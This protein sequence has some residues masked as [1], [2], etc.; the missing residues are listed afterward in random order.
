M[1]RPLPRAGTF[2]TPSSRRL[3]E[4]GSQTSYRPSGSYNSHRNVPAPPAPSMASASSGRSPHPGT[5]AYHA[6]SS[7]PY[8]TLPPQPRAGAKSPLF[9][10]AVVMVDE[11]TEPGIG[12]IEAEHKRVELVTMILAGGD[13]RHGSA[14]S[15][16]SPGAAVAFAIRKRLKSE[17]YVAVRNTLALLDEVMRTCPYF[18]RYIANDKFF[19][20]MWRFVDPDYKTD[21]RG[22]LPFVGRAA[23][24]NAAASRS[25]QINVDLA[26]RVLILIRAWA[27]DLSMMYNGTYDSD[28]GFLIER[29]SQKRLRIKFPAVPTNTGT[30]WV[31][32]VGNSIPSGSGSRFAS[33]NGAAGASSSAGGR[34]RGTI[35]KTTT[36]LPQSLSLAEVEN[37]INMLANILEKAN[38]ISE[39]RAELC[40]DLA[41]RCRLVHQNIDT[42]SARMEKDEDLSLAIRVSERL[43]STLAVYDKALETGVLDN[44]PPVVEGLGDSDS[45]DEGYGGSEDDGLRSASRTNSLPIRRVNDDHV[46][47][48]DED[49]YSDTAGASGDGIFIP[50]PSRRGRVDRSVDYAAAESGSS[51]RAADREEAVEDRSRDK[52]RRAKE[53][54]AEKKSERK[55]RKLDAN[56]S[57][58]SDRSEKLPSGKNGKSSKKNRE[59]S[60]EVALLAKSSSKQTGT[61]SSPAS[62]TGHL[63]DIA[64]AADTRSSS[65]SASSAGKKD[66]VF[67]SLGERY[68]SSKSKGS[69]TSPQA[70]DTGSNNAAFLSA[71]S[72]VGGAGGADI[73]TGLQNLAL[74]SQQ[75]HGQ[76]LDQALPQHQKQPT[77]QQMSQQP[78]QHPMM[79]Y[80]SVM[81]LPNPLA[82][83]MYSSYNPNAIPQS[84]YSTLQSAYN[85][86]NPAMYYS[87]I[88]PMAAYTSMNPLAQQ[89]SQQPQQ[90][91][92]QPKYHPQ[93]S[94]MDVPPPLTSQSMSGQMPSMQAT[95]PVMSGY[96]PT[97]Q[98][99]LPTLQNLSAPNPAP[100]PPPPP[101]PSS[102]TT[103]TNAPAPPPSQPLPPQV[104]VPSPQET[105]NSL[106]QHS[107]VEQTQQ[108]QQPPQLMQPQMMMHP[109][110]MMQH[111]PYASRSGQQPMIS[112]PFMYASMNGQQPLQDNSHQHTQQ[113]QQQQQQ[114]HQHQQKLAQQQLA[115]QQQLAEQQMAMMRAH[116]G[117]MQ[118]G[119]MHPPSGMMQ[120]PMPG[121]P[122]QDDAYQ[123]LAKAAADYQAAATA[124]QSMQGMAPLQQTAPADSTASVSTASLS[125][126]SLPIASASLAP[127]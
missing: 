42:M 59:S 116:A 82:M 103:V 98:A 94:E 37:T 8:G 65:S 74:V 112:S 55:E 79:P 31:C 113:Q 114:E 122:A 21:V 25:N 92:Q 19:R 69:V 50:P 39:V 99:S 17:D 105:S 18:Y 95:S 46:R 72:V 76:P 100:A 89:Q 107:Q 64:T 51:K 11:A 27:E 63:V 125:S 34:R 102:Y 56:S 77:M 97:M 118:P 2:A 14:S 85:T 52:T 75:Q 87:S 96:L 126:A 71:A 101:S 45:E 111:N 7:G 73:V 3:S 1:S 91:Q 40:A 13:P 54:E 24:K 80:G 104:S 68:T 32:N 58:T 70:S 81:M 9:T 57:R 117:M 121:A 10:R 62:P 6:A 47:D 83:S 30:P 28:A 29:Y 36:P 23:T 106:S 20:R 33:Y 61:K 108:Y 120:Q 44:A 4:S 86:V 90:H 38:D 12:E 16:H 5:A 124:Y 48:D 22:K 110:M 127:Q 78:Q 41:S 109:Q 119:M 43:Q 66:D 53:R 15:A 84:Q 123:K 26:E 93:M 67:A 49:A 60:G 115:Q 88:N 35:S